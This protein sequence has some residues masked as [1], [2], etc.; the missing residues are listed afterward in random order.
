[1]VLDMQ[2][3][4]MYTVYRKML[5]KKRDGPVVD[6]YP[7]SQTLWF[8]S[9]LCHR[10]LVW[11]LG[12]SF[13]LILLRCNHLSAIT[14]AKHASWSPRNAK[15]VT[16]GLN[17]ECLLHSLTEAHT[18]FFHTLCHRRG[19][20]AETLSQ[21]RFTGC[22]CK[23]WSIHLCFD[24]FYFIFSRLPHLTSP[25]TPQWMLGSFMTPRHTPSMLSRCST[26]RSQS[27]RQQHSHH[28][29]YFTLLLQ[30]M[31]SLPVCSAGILQVLMQ[32]TDFS[33]SFKGPYMKRLSHEHLWDHQAVPRCS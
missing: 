3:L 11:L 17:K 27:H 31:F 8:E 15:S 26:S 13:P 22:C 18:A 30:E 2:I 28:H 23:E 32:E 5:T 4:S 21:M 29:R 6:T 12:K 33:M 19:L 24:L 1:M 10:Q 20:L 16:T 14:S 7:V 25:S 9:S